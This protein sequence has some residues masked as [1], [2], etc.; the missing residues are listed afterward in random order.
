MPSVLFHP[1]HRLWLLRG[2]TSAYAIRLAEDDSV[3][4]VHWGAALTLDQAAELPERVSPAASSFESVA[5]VDELAVEGGARFGPPSLLVRFADGTRGVEWRY[6][7]HDVDGGHLRI[8]LR[9]RHY[10][11]HVTLNYRVHDD[12]DVIER[13]TNVENRDET[14]PVTVLRCDSAAW[15]APHRAHY[16]MSHLVG[17]WNSEFQVR[18]TD[19]PVAETVLTSRRG[20]TSHHANPWLAVDDGTACE[21]CGE[22]WSTALAWSGSWRIS[23]HRDPVGRT[24]WTGGFGHEGLSWS[25]APGEALET[26]VFAGLYTANGFGAASR[27]WHAHVRARVLAHPDET[28]PV[29]YNSWEATGFDVDE[30]G[31]MAL[32]ARA[33]SLGVELFVMDDGWFG[34][35]RS[36]RAGLGDWAPNPD[37]FPSGLGPLAAEVRR[38]GMR[39]GIWVEPEMVNPDSDLYRAHPDWVL[40][41]ANRGRTEMRHQLVL[42]LARPDAAE[43]T[44]TWLDRL[45][46]EHAIDFLK[47]D[48]NRPFTEAG[49]PGHGDPDR[50]WIEHTR[51][52]YRIMD[53][54]RA[55]H[56]GLRIEACSG[57]GG[58][59]DLGILAR[60][61]QVWASD[62]TDP[63]DRIGIQRGFSQLYPAQVMSAW[64]TDSPN[65][66]T[67]RRTPLRFRFHVA[68]AGVPGIGGDLTTW[69][70]E[71][72]KESAELV[73]VYKRIR[74]VVQ[75]GA[76]H[77]LRGDGMLTGV[78]YVREDEHVVLAWCPTRA[79]GHSPAPLRLAAVRPDAVYRDL[80]TGATYPGAVLLQSGLP[81]GLPP[82]DH[83]SALVRLRRV[84]Q[85]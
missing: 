64:V 3:R 35:R 13:W 85:A 60:T 26:P 6:T 45:V 16:R 31:Q 25:L 44:H 75:H 23:L 56:P 40:H 53:R 77:R 48:A 36:E 21:N 1:D 72:L 47:W 71:E 50:L 68:M 74:H 30:A 80:D 39:F 19:V 32:A 41:M 46:A 15:A 29:L 18:R 82:G 84:D 17:G 73:A 67:A 51:S 70:Q 65:V 4:H 22:V 79:F 8:H 12:S 55:D 42:N 5:G 2:P 54:L 83:A 43:W 24:T 10:P 76:Q 11:L 62:N 34:G 59:A 7:G 9:D 14:A 20:M 27:A 49:W 69:T 33:A 58:R 57:G 81:L 37:R 38:L 61:D 52:V 28:R 78:E 66:A 63:V